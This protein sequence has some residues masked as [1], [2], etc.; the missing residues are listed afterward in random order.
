M[1]VLWKEASNGNELAD[2]PAGIVFYVKMRC[3]QK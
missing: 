3:I 1:A 2:K